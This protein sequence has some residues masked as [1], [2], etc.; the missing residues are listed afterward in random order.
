M[1]LTRD[2]LT[3]LQ[4]SYANEPLQAVLGAGTVGSA[5]A[6]AKGAVPDDWKLGKALGHKAVLPV[7]VLA[8]AAYGWKKAREQNQGMHDLVKTLKGKSDKDT[9][10]NKLLNELEDKQF[11]PSSAAMQGAMAVPV[12]E[13]LPEAVSAIRKAKD[14]SFKGIGKGL[15]SAVG[16]SLPVV[17][18][19]SAIAAG[20]GATLRQREEREAVRQLEKRSSMSNKYLEKI[21]EMSEDPLVPNAP[22]TSVVGGTIGATGLR[23]ADYAKVYKGGVARTFGLP[24]MIGSLA[25]PYIWAKNKQYDT[26]EAVEKAISDKDLAGKAR[27]LRKLKEDMARS[28]PAIE[29][30]A[31]SVLPMAVGMVSPIPGVASVVGSYGRRAQMQEHIDNLSGR[32][33]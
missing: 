7:G 11:S 1:S 23:L 30:I 13:V 21:A 24:V 28:S 14:Y 33:R 12:L 10:R 2:Q 25:A 17:A 6:M 22:L 5:L 16:P 31:G 4:D 9:A 20:A 26:R 29:G 15:A 18:A 32:G 27:L 3:T 8:G 19:A